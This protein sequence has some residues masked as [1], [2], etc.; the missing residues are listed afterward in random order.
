MS[1]FFTLNGFP[2][3]I[4]ECQESDDSIRERGRAVGGSAFVNVTASKR[5]WDMTTG[6]LDLTTAQALKSLL[7]PDLNGNVWANVTPTTISNKGKELRNTGSLSNVGTAKTPSLALSPDVDNVKILDDE[8]L[9][10]HTVAMW[11]TPNLFADYAHYIRRSDGDVFINAVRATGASTPF[12]VNST[13]VILDNSGERYD[14][15]VVLPFEI[16]DEWALNWDLEAQFGFSEL[17]ELRA[18]G[19]FVDGEEVT[20]LGLDPVVRVMQ[21]SGLLARVDFQL[22]EV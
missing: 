16:P 4:S 6:L 3:G 22:L 7:R 17:P 9:S 20:V 12:T 19:D 10:T 8:D 1:H 15:I 5:I 13:E 21:G 11:H 14:D 2:I 18:S